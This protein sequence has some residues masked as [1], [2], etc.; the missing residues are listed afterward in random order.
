MIKRFRRITHSNSDNEAKFYLKSHSWNFD[1][2]VKEFKDDVLWESSNPPR[3][4]L[5]KKC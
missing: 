1:Y 4:P 5:S 3:N 2:A